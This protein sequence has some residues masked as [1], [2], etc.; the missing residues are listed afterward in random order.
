[1]KPKPPNKYI[2]CLKEIIVTKL[3][4]QDILDKLPEG[5]DLGDTLFYCAD[6]E[7]YMNYKENMENYRYNTDFQKYEKAMKEYKEYIKKEYEELNKE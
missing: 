5:T 1:M 3:S 2:T 6:D 7:V 4:L